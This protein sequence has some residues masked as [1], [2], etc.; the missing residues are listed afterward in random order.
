MKPIP[1]FSKYSVTKDGQIY[2]SISNK[3]LKNYLTNTEYYAVKLI[4]DSGAKKKVLIHRAVAT[5]YL[6]NSLNKRIVNH[7]DGDKLNN[8]VSN[9][10]WATDSENI[11]HAFENGLCST[12]ASLDYSQLESITNSLLVG[13]TWSSVTEGLN[14]SDP[15]TVRKLCKRHFYRQGR[16]SEFKHLCRV[17]KDRIV[18]SRASKICTVDELGNITTY[19]SMQEA[20][21]LING[22]A[23]GIHKSISKG[24]K[25]R[26]YAWSRL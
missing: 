18:A 13:G 8:D 23:G 19:K 3:F 21:R 12:N 26:G 1:N 6:P 4:S 16:E 17:I 5:T 15:S 9:L 11:R 20:A 24:T 22:N 2:S 14:I 10:E 7:I 25:Y